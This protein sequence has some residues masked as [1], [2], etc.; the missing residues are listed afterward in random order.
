METL[1]IY[2]DL[3]ARENLIQQFMTHGI[4]DNKGIQEILELVGLNSTGKR[5]VKDFSLGMRQRPGIDI[6]L[7]G[8]PDFLVLDEPNNGLDPQGIIEIREL[9]LRRNRDKG[10]TV[11]MSVWVDVQDT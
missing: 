2:L 10:I 9:I 6:A 1:S 11:H 4:P 7:A 8:N 3:S 5:K